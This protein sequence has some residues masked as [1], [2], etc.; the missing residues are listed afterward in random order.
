MG[1]SIH[2]GSILDAK[3]DYIVNPANSFLNHAGGLARVIAE[4]ATAPF[5]PYPC[6]RFTT[7]PDGSPVALMRAARD[8][9]VHRVNQWIADHETAPLIPTGRCHL[10]SAGALPFK[11]VYHAVGPI[12]AGGGFYE[13]DLLELA[14][15]SVYEVL[16]QGASVAF[17]AISAG[18]FGVPIEAVARVA[19]TVARWYEDDF[20]TEFWLFTDEHRDAFAAQSGDPLFG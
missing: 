9:H 15:E 20:E 3:V 7:G 18:I 4:A 11:G 19:M 6:S 17:P 5:S 13:L 2:Q 1:I 14:Y 10:T 8:K 12:W 16:P